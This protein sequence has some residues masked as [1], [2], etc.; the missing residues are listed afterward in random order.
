MGSQH[1]QQRKETPSLPTASNESSFPLSW[2]QS[3]PRKANYQCRARGSW[4][5]SVNSQTLM[6]HSGRCWG[7]SEVMGD[8]PAHERKPCWGW[9]HYQLM[10]GACLGISSSQPTKQQAEGLMLL[11]KWT[12]IKQERLES[13][14]PCNIICWLLGASPHLTGAFLSGKSGWVLL[15]QLQHWFPVR[16]RKGVIFSSFVSSQNEKETNK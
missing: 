13:F 6:R 14:F 8:P 12:S 4:P 2:S 9:G 1:G 16:S 10:Q 7:Y 3:S 11:N 5:Y 15:A